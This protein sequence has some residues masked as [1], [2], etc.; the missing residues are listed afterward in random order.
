MIRKLIFGTKY[1]MH[2][3]WGW[4]K[5]DLW[6]DLDAGTLTLAGER[7]F[8]VVKDQ[9]QEISFEFAEGWREYLMDESHPQFKK[10]YDDIFNQMRKGVG[11]GKGQKGKKQE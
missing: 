1:I 8:T 4:A 9:D 11:K 3:E 2:K 5:S 10:L 7:M 6:A